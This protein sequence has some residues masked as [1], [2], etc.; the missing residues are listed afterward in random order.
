[1]LRPTSRLANWSSMY[2]FM[3]WMMDTTAM[4]KVTPISTPI[5]EKK[6]LSF[7]D[8]M[9]R[10]AIRTASRSGTYAA[11]PRLSRSLSTRPSRSA[12]LVSQDGGK[13]WTLQYVREDNRSVTVAVPELVTV[14]LNRWMARRR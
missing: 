13:S 6:L 7:C 12:E 14:E 4:R 2:T 10:S 1:M 5:R 3:P 9:V 8:R 11:A